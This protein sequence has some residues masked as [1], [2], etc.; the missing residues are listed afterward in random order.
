MKQVKVT[1][2][3]FILS[4]FQGEKTAE[5]KSVSLCR[6]MMCDRCGIMCDKQ[7][8]G[9]RRGARERQN[10]EDKDRKCQTLA[11]AKSSVVVF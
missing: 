8:G 3:D 1:D 9:G 10:K 5:R 2:S 6:T 4:S 7:R 11:G